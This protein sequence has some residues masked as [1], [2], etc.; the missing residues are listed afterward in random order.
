[1]KGILQL[2]NF[3]SIAGVILFFYFWSPSWRC[4]RRESKI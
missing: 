2:K 3:F 4:Y 1:M